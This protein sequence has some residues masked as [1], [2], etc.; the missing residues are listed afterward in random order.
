MAFLGYIADFMLML[1]KG[2]SWLWN[3]IL[4]QGEG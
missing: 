1:H 3:L 2:A 4:K